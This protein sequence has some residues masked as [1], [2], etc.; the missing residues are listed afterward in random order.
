MD[1][2]QIENLDNGSSFFV[3]FNPTEYS[4]EDGS[5]WQDQGRNRQ[6]PELQYTGGER[7]KLTMELFFDTY[8]ADSDVRV[9]TAV[10]AKL[11]VRLVERVAI[12]KRAQQLIVAGSALVDT[13]HDGIDDQQDNS[14]TATPEIVPDGFFDDGGEFGALCHLLLSGP[15]DWQTPGCGADG[16]ED[17][18]DLAA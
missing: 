5:S 4:F 18:R 15:R 11:L 7:S 2:L 8:E 17:G 3:L 10:L 9:Y 13:G 12:G 16:E 14:G 1:K 6:R